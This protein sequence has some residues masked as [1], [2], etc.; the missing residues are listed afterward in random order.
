[1]RLSNQRRARQ[2]RLYNPNFRNM[3]EKNAQL[4]TR[5]KRGAYFQPR[6]PDV[7]HI[8]RP[9]RRPDILPNDD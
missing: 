3:R 7:S 6:A 9:A 1:M 2:M 5:Q 8:L 4:P